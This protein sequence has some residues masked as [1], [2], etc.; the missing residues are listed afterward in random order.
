MVA[1]NFSFLKIFTWFLGGA[2][3][4]VEKSFFVE[5]LKIDVG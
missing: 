2:T 3:V 4:Q 5:N 1:F